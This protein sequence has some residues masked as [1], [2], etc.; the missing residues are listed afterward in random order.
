[1]DYCDASFVSIDGTNSDAGIVT[2]PDSMVSEMEYIVSLNSFAFL[3]RFQ[4]LVSRLDIPVTVLLIPETST[5][6]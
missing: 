1:M 3:L 6:Y 4:T 2:S 5:T